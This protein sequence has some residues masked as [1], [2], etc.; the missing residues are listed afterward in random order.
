MACARGGAPPVGEDPSDASRRDGGTD[1]AVDWLGPAE[2][3]WRWCRRSNG[4]IEWW[5]AIVTR[6]GFNLA[7]EELGASRPRDIGHD[8]DDRR[9]GINQHG[10]TAQKQPDADMSFPAE[11]NGVA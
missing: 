11:K 5:L 7:L 1:L 9:L 4:R 6:Q 8:R 10:P 3:V 2:E